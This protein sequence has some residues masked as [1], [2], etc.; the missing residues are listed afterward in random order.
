MDPDPAFFVIDLQ[1]ANKKNCFFPEFF[2]LLLLKVHV[3]YFLKIKSKRNY[4]TVGIKGFLTIFL[5]DDRR[6]RI[7]EA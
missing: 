6:I 3:P 2:Y 4:K 5:F 1:D 7:Q